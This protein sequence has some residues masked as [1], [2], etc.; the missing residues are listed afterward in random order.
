MYYTV[1]A[2]GKIKTAKAADGK[3]YNIIAYD[4]VNGFELDTDSDGKDDVDKLGHTVYYTYN[5]VSIAYDV[6]KGETADKNGDGKIDTDKYGNN[7]YYVKNSETDAI[8][9]DT[10]KGGAL[11]NDGDGDLDKDSFGNKIYYNYDLCIAYNTSNGVRINETDKNGAEITEEFSAAEKA[12]IKEEAEK[13]FEIAENGNYDSFEELL[14][15]YDNNYSI[16]TE[17]ERDTLIYL[18]AD[19]SY[20][21]GS[22]L[23]NDLYGKIAD[24]DAG[25]KLIYESDYGYH[26]IMR[27]EPETAAYSETKYEFYFESFVSNLTN[28]LFFARLEPYLNGITIKEKY[29][30]KVDISTITPNYN[31]Y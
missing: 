25:E 24:V 2:D 22:E 5:N 10:E 26:I 31:F 13:I 7:I 21:A 30:E 19:E 4:T 3:T 9:Y 27:Y 11:D 20:T 14:M 29:K 8:S 15:I 28:E 16:A 23:M 1:D 12:K 17:E 18:S 6:V